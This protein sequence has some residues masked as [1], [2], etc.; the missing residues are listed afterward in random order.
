MTPS[1][2]PGA[3][4]GLRVV[5]LSRVLGDDAAEADVEVLE[6]QLRFDEPPAGDENPLKTD[7]DG[8][9]ERLRAAIAAA[10]QAVSRD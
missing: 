10:Q 4:A 1:L 7:G 2:T 3:L 5:D 6:R 9:L 8:D